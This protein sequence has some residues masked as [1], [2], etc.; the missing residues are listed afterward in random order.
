MDFNE[1]LEQVEDYLSG[2]TENTIEPSSLATFAHNHSTDSTVLRKLAKKLE[3]LGI[4]R[5]G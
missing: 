1:T 5:I 4:K 2:K 3:E